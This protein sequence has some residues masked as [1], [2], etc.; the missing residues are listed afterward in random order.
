MENI[1]LLTCK[2]PMVHD[3]LYLVRTVVDAL[4]QGK[5]YQFLVYG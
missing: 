3:E 5:I 4:L 2:E 1:T